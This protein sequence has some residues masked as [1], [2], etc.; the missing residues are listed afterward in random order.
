M[1]RRTREGR[2]KGGRKEEGPL[3]RDHTRSETEKLLPHLLSTWDTG[4]LSLSSPSGSKGPRISKPGLQRYGRTD[5]LRVAVCRTCVQ[6]HASPR[7]HANAEWGS[8]C[9]PE[10]ARP[11]GA[12]CC[13]PGEAVRASTQA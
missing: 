8:P 3:P 7:T 12:T 10:R 6:A 4:K 1:R 2:P 13:C 11:R 9:R 5:L